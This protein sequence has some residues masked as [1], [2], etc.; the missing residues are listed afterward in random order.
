MP[1]QPR[2]RETMGDIYAKVWPNAT[3]DLLA[4]IYQLLGDPNE[5][6]PS[7]MEILRAFEGE[8]GEE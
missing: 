5:I 7:F 3:S 2:R 4:Q 8:T 1:E 6:V